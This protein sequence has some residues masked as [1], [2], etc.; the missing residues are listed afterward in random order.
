MSSGVW[1]ALVVM[2][3]LFLA[4]VP[5]SF[6]LILSTLSYFVVSA[7]L[8]LIAVVQRLVGGLESVPLLCIPFFITAG[9]LPSEVLAGL[10]T[11]L[12]E[13]GFQLPPGYSMEYGGEAAK[14]DDGVDGCG[15]QRRDR[16][17]HRDPRRRPSP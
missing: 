14:R 10:Q 11:R 4:D 3:L 8:P 5:I 12:A 13:N 6:A 1:V 16:G 2:L 9:V 7:D 15:D 17:T